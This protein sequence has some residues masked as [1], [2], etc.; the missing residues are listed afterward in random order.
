MGN[1]SMSQFHTGLLRFL[2]AV[3]FCRK[4]WCINK[5][6]TMIFTI[7]LGI[8]VI[9]AC[10][11]F[12]R[13]CHVFWQLLVTV[14]NDDVSTNWW[15]WFSSLSLVYGSYEHVP[16]LYGVVTFFDSCWLLYK[17]MMYQQIDDYD[18]HYWAWYVGHTSM[19]HFHTG[20]SRFLTAV[21]YCRKWWCINKWIIIFIIEL[22]I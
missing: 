18:F 19:S 3:G 14:E 4:W 17:M 9:R 22:G 13:G 11:N 20:L 6:M 2:T 1:T 12:I 16:I 5:L 21:G 10:P 7:E 15:L 8:W